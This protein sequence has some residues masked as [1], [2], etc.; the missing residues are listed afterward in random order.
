M[1]KNPPIKRS[2]GTT[3]LKHGPFMLILASLVIKVFMIADPHCKGH[4]LKLIKQTFLPV[5]PKKT[6][7]RF[8]F[9]HE[10]RPLRRD[11]RLETWGFSTMFI[12][13]FLKIINFTVLRLDIWLDIYLRVG[14]FWFL[15]KLPARVS[16]SQAEKQ[17]TPV[18][19]HLIH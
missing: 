17:P 1:N 7:T 2:E 11:L 8:S 19:D 18:T 14:I 4:F 13:L 3:P 15:C 5:I 12:C 16:N 9:L 10:S 6:M